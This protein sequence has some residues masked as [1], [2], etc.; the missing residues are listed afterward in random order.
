MH[1]NIKFTIIT[2]F[3][4]LLLLIPTASALEPFIITENTI[5]DLTENTVYVTIKENTGK[6]QNIN[7][8][9]IFTN[10]TEN[11][12]ISYKDVRLNQSYQ[13]SVYN[14][15]NVS[16]GKYTT[17]NITYWNETYYNN[18]T[19][20]SYNVTMNKTNYYNNTGALMTCAY[21][22]GDKSC[23]QLQHVLTGYET[24]Y[25]YL[26]IPG[27]KEKI[28]INGLKIEQKQDGIPLPKNSIVQLKY[29]V[30]HPIAYGNKIS[31]YINKYDIQV[32]SATNECSILDPTWWNSSWNYRIDSYIVN[33]S[34]PYQILLNV[35]NASGT[36]NATTV[37]CNGHCNKN[38]TDVRFTLDNTTILP[39][40]IE[41]NNTGKMWVNVTANGTV[42]MYYGNTEALTPVSNGNATFLQWHGFDNVAYHDSN[43]LTPTKFLYKVKFKLIN[44]GAGR[45]FGTSKTGDFTADDGF[46]YESSTTGNVRYMVARNGALITYVEKVG[47]LS[48]DVYHIIDIIFIGSSVS[49]HEDG[50]HWNV[51]STNLPNENMGLS[52]QLV[53]GN[54]EQEYAFARSYSA[55]IPVF[56]TWTTE[57]SYPPQY[58]DKTVTHNIIVLTQI[59]FN[60][61]VAP[62]LYNVSISQ[63]LLIGQNI[64]VSKIVASVSYGINISQS[65]NISDSVLVSKIV[66]PVS[67]SIKVNQSIELL[68]S[69]SILKTPSPV[70]YIISVSQI[71]TIDNK[72]IMIST[73]T[74]AISGTILNILGSPISFARVDLTGTFDIA[75]VNG[76]YEI[77]GLTSG[78]YSIL[79]RAAGYWNNTQ[80]K[81]IT[82]NTSLDITLK[83]ALAIPPQ[84]TPGFEGMIMIIS[85]VTI[86]FIRRRKC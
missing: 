56:G 77:S 27:L 54:Y 49:F 69:V 58:Y 66:A 18:V 76:H 75:D 59:D 45:R 8:S 46:T 73:G 32:C 85:I 33:G 68:Q 62:V 11:K 7:I 83:E 4:V 28:V 23:Y 16:I 71:I 74:S 31:D 37:F 26:P 40:W 14:W 17:S 43:I 38:F 6:D 53:S 57:T 36:N 44:T 1:P 50:V 29:T 82:G 25:D 22:L 67:Y 35:S 86:Y 55:I 9:H 65:I 51:I 21:V 13:S 5:Y 80:T 15:Q 19:N 81:E 78:S 72:I 70:N 10:G 24:K 79:T 30:K 63:S 84:D 48:L 41:D 61:I 60:K 2:V 12:N 34:R 42:N 64:D 52:V 47:S 20:T 3:I 39:Y